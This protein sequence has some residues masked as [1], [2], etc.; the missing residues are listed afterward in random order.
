MKTRKC[1]STSICLM[2]FLLL[3]A[4]ESMAQERAFEVPATNPFGKIVQRVAAT[5]IEV[6]YNRPSIKGRKIFGELVPFGQVWRTGSDASTKITFSTAVIFNEKPLEAGAYELFTI[7][8][9]NEWTIILQSNKNQWGSYRYDAESDVHRSTVKPVKLCY[10]V[11]TFTIS[12]DAVTSRS[13]EIS[14]A[15]ENSKISIPV[16]IDLQATV[17]PQLE[18][19]LTK[20]EKRSYFKAAMFYFENDLDVNRAAELMALAIN[21]NPNHLGMLYRQALILQRKGDTQ[22][23]IAASEKSLAEAKK[24]GRELRDEYVKLNTQLLTQLRSK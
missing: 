1:N 7:P 12:V 16:L 15:W 9:E 23:A 21:D 6:N 3:A 18:E 24:A 22:A 20:G 13:A 10:S 17:I 11:E 5:D 14:L 2:T 8:A 19:A 4:I